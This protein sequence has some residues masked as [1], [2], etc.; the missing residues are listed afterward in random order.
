MGPAI[1]QVAAK[2]IAHRNSTADGGE[3]RRLSPGACFQQPLASQGVGDPRFEQNAKRRPQIQ[4]TS[5]LVREVGKDV[6]R[7]ETAIKAIEES[8]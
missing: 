3:W 6:V 8:I 2:K 5:S 1:L 4:P 7:P